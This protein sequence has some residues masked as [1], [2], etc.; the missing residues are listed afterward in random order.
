MNL[1]PCRKRLGKALS[2]HTNKSNNTYDQDI[3]IRNLS[4]NRFDNTATANKQLLLKMAGNNKK[5]PSSKSEDPAEKKLGSA[6]SCYT[7]KSNGAY[8]QEFDIEIRNLRP[9]WFKNRSHNDKQ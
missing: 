9:D 8:D 5:R 1:K 4:S 6:L 2:H 7:C 3:E